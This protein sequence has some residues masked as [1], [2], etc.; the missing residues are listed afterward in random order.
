MK[1]NTTKQKIP[2]QTKNPNPSPLQKGELKSKEKS[3]FLW[4]LEL[5][6]SIFLPHLHKSAATSW[7]PMKKFSCQHFAACNI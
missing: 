4:Y 3:C 6:P 7:G 5:Q 2:K 1:K